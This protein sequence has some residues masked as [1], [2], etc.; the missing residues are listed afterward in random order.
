MYI[1][2]SISGA[3]LPP[4]PVDFSGEGGGRLGFHPGLGFD[5]KRFNFNID[6][7]YLTKS[8]VELTELGVGG[9]DTMFRN[10][11]YDVTI[12]FFLFGGKPS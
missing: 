12:G 8:D 9:V 4:G 5:W 1:V 11:H 10:S 6:L 7:N 3:Y 2:D